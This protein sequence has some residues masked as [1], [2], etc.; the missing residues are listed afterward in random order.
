MP[1]T[2]ITITERSSTDHGFTAELAFNHQRRYQITITPPFDAKQESHLAW[3]FEKYLAFPFTET[4]RFE[5]VGNSI[6]NYGEHLFKQVF[7]APD[8][9]GDYRDALR[10]GFTLEILGSPA[11]HALHWESLK[12]PNHPQP[13]ALEH[14]IVRKPS[15]F[16]T[17]Y[18]P[19]TPQESPT[20]NVLL[21]VA[22]PNGRNDVA[23]RTIS[24]PLVNMV[25][26]AQL[27]VQFDIL[28]PATFQ[29]LIQH[30]ENV[31]TQKGKGFYHIVHFDVH[32]AVLDYATAQKAE[33]AGRITFDYGRGELQPFEGKQ[34]FIFLQHEQTGKA[35]PIGAKTLTDLLFQHGIPVV[36]LNACQSAQQENTSSETS[37]ASYL[38][39]AGPQAVV[40][41]AYSVTVSA[42]KLFMQHL[43]EQLFQKQ[44]LTEAIRRA[45]LELYHQKERQAYYNQQVKL[46]DWLLPVVYQGTTQVEF[47][48]REFTP[49]EEKRFS[50]SQEP[51]TDYGFFGRD[52]DILEIETHLLKNNIVLIKG[53]SGVGKTTLLKH[54]EYW[55]EI[56]HWL[57]H[58][59]TFY[60]GYKRE[61]TFNIDT[62][63]NQLGISKEQY[64]S[65]LNRDKYLLIFDDLENL[66]DEQRAV[67]SDFLQPL[68]GGKSIVLLG[69]RTGKTLFEGAYQESI[70]DLG[71]LDSIAV[72]DLISK[73]KDSLKMSFDMTE[74]SMLINPLGGHPRSLETLLKITKRKPEIIEQAI[75]EKKKESEGST[76]YTTNLHKIIEADLFYQGLTEI[77][78]KFLLNLIPFGHHIDSELFKIFITE[79]NE[80]RLFSG[81]EK[82][83]LSHLSFISTQSKHIRKIASHWIC[84]PEFY[85]I[86]LSNYYTEN[87][88][89]YHIHNSCFNVA[90]EKFISDLLSSNLSDEEF[91]QFIKPILKQQSKSIN[92]CFREQCNDFIDS[93]KKF[94]ESLL[95]AG[96]EKENINTLVDQVNK[97]LMNSLSSNT[98]TQNNQGK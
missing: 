16:N 60:F 51:N 38:M 44:P 95:L 25:R 14:V 96:E 64:R 72:S 84:S 7:Q 22:R 15:H 31:K 89:E 70:Y 23:Y 50:E 74:L 77:R 67:L 65:T 58:N 42:A 3:Y 27:R 66:L 86:L 85:D 37:L 1:P 69:S 9:Y 55:W 97:G 48:L 11:F 5:Q 10:T 41:M 61:E 39:Q 80:F 57:E 18:Q 30:L 46:E 8:A 90:I 45:R 87:D 81:I 34:A 24:A 26:T 76:T 94:I 93:S 21:V 2:L 92:R 35:A 36:L 71:G 6:E 29:A 98:D 59:K 75:K 79:L 52:W 20:L 47:P 56:T 88:K 12:D 91:E 19:I 62:F 32:G 82:N 83:S 68:I 17:A 43:Y 63:C 4:V 53:A 49:E 28:R 78:R 33:T 73:M 40:G 13:F 54:L